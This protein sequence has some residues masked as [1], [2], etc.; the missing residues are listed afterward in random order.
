[1]LLLLWLFNLLFASAVYFQFSGYFLGL[2]ETRAAGGSFLKAI[3]FNTVFEMLAFD[4]G[5]I[6]RIIS[7]A[8]FLMLIYGF[9]SI[10]LGGGILHT[11]WTGRGGGE[12]ADR[13]RLAPLFFH[14]A[15]RYFGRF[16]RLFLCS[17]AL[18]AAAIVALMIL[19]GV[20]KPLS[21]DT[22]NES[23]MF[24]AIL[25]QVIVGL[26]LAFLVKMIIDYARIR[27]VAED[28]TAALGSLLRAIG[29]VFRNFGKTL[30]LYYFYMLTGAILIALF[31][32]ID[33]SIKNTPMFAVLVAFLISQI[34]ILSRGWIKIGLQAAQMDFF[35]SAFPTPPLAPTP[36][37]AFEP[38]PPQTEAAPQTEEPPKTDL[39][40]EIR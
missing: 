6:G 16:F 12:T 37:P 3:D 1:M 25:A 8:T 9:F 33:A 29:F 4:G 39:E 15:G 31:W 17:L 23:L 22:P 32:A 13:R 27:M 30:A 18:W 11:L 24:W 38:F 34:F 28:S 35:R 7:L 14:G 40:P 10:F 26:F 5:A 21:S 36:P 19:M 20:L 2:L